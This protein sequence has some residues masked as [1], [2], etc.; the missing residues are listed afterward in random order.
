MRALL[1]VLLLASTSA[2]GDDVAFLVLE[3]DATKLV[4]GI[5]EGL[6]S[7]DPLTRATAARVATVRNV[8]AVVPQL[9]ARLAT[10]NDAMVARELIRGMAIV[11]GESHVDTLI[12]ASARFPANMDEA[13][14]DAYARGGAIDLYFRKLRNLRGVG[15]FFRMA[16]WGKPQ[17]VSYVAARLVGANDERGW[18]SFLDT[19]VEAETDLDPNVL[20]SALD[21]TNDAIRTPAVWYVARNFAGGANRIAPA[22]RERLLAPR[23][24]QG[25]ESEEFGRELVRRILGGKASTAPRLLAWLRSEQ[26]RAMLFA[27]P[28]E[29]HDLLTREEIA[30]LR[31]HCPKDNADCIPRKGRS[32]RD[33]ARRAPRPSFFLPDHL[34]RNLARR[35][36]DATKCSEPWTGS[37]QAQLDGQGRVR[38]L[39]LGPLAP[40]GGCAKTLR[41]MML[42][43]L[44]RNVSI[45]SSRASGDV[46]YVK[47]ARA[48]PCVDE[49]VPSN[50][51]GATVLFHSDAVEPALP[52]ERMEPLFPESVRRAM[53]MRGSA[54]I[55][56]QALI[57]SDG[58]VGALHLLKQS[59]WPELNASALL[60]VSQWKFEP[61]RRNGE[62]VDALFS[63]TM[64]FRTGF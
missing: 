51:I 29:V 5:T 48:V 59:Q 43:T 54:A 36:I 60:S 17:M 39:N 31:S 25:S 44:A 19:L 9:A 7:N 24:G 2:F 46:L 6:Q 38:A 30:A 13:L 45:N 22:I 49:E 40:A 52:K 16:L 47:A 3:E 62:P 23:D 14:A 53:R 26:G 63:L 35:L 27:S 57:T 1:L 10:E 34:P 21:A 15:D 41:T 50:A 61:A 28:D 55:D 18:R 11:G 64:S 32:L 42:L 56:I 58:C 33:T 20:G 8:Q 4:S 37:A 12:A